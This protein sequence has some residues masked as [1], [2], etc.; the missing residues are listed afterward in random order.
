[1]YLLDTSVFSEFAKPEPSPNVLEW[2]RTVK[3]AEQHLSVLVL[4]E[5]LRGVAR[6]PDGERRWALGQDAVGQGF[7]HRGP[8]PFTEADP[9]HAEHRGRRV[10]RPWFCPWYPPPPVRTK[11]PM[12]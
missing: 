6:K 2:A 10:R 9:R 12:Q 3:E 5:L 11:D 7:P 1:M 8:G 4:G